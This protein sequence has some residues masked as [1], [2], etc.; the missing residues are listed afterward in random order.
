MDTP[1]FMDMIANYG[2]LLQY[3]KW[4][5]KNIDVINALTKLT[6]RT[7]PFLPWNNEETIESFVYDCLYRNE[8]KL[9]LVEGEMGA[10]N[11]TVIDDY[12]ENAN[13]IIQ[14]VDNNFM[15]NLN[16]IYVAMWLM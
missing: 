1:N 8:F 12:L 3:G 15:C 9:D 10:K 16:Y 5:R 6:K 7:F 11:L 13:K 14:E 2:D 4:K